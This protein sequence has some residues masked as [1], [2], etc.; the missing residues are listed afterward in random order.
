VIAADGFVVNIKMGSV[1]FDTLKGKVS[2]IEC[3]KMIEGQEYE[4]KLVGA[5]RDRVQHV[6]LKDR[7]VDFHFI[8][9]LCPI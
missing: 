5:T 3:L 4:V 7:S 9:C 8:V 1:C 6:Q 2:T